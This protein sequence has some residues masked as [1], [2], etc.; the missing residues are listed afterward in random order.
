MRL[1]KYLAHAGVASRRRAEKLVAAGRVQLDGATVRDPAIDVS[2]PSDVRVDG[3]RVRPQR[4]EHYALNKPLGVVSTA[5]DPRGRPKVTEL[6]ETSTRLYPVGRLDANTSGL[7]LLTNDGELANRIM[8]PRYEV[9]K[10]YR[11][12]VGAR[13]S[14]AGLEALRCGVQLEDGVTAPARVRLVRAGADD[15]VIEITIHEGRKR[16]VRRMCEAIGHPVLELCRTRI[17]NVELGNLADARYRPLR[18]RELAELRR[19]AGLRA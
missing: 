3:R 7:I 12:R 17:A 6:I 4:Y 18:A 5:D 8:H 16:Q 13:L 14:R 11:A 15:S 10:S 19:A 9:K 1:V 2:A